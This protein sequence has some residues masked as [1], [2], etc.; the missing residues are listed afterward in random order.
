M[1]RHVPKVPYGPCMLI[2]RTIQ[3]FILDCQKL[4]SERT[5]ILMEI[6]ATWQNI[7]NCEMSFTEL[8]NNSQLQILLE[9]L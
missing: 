1:C 7:Q 9:E 2:L 6:S 3:H 5:K 8:D 4:E